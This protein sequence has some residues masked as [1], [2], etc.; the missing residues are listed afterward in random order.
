MKSSY[1][2]AHVMPWV[3][4]G[5]T[6]HATLR[7]AEAVRAGGFESVM[8]CLRE[9]DETQ[10]FFAAKGFPIIEYDAVEPS[11]TKAWRTRRENEMLA[12][13]FKQHGI[14][15]VHCADVCAAL[16]ANRAGRM[17][18]LPVI[19]HVRNPHGRESIGW[20]ER[21]FLRDIGQWVFVSQDTWRKFG[22]DVPE[23]RGV[24]IYDGIDAE[25]DDA[26]LEAAK[27]EARSSV[28]AEFGI[29]DDEKI[30]GMVARISPQKDFMTLARAA[31]RVTGNAAPQV[32]FL[33]VGD[34]ENTSAHREH[35]AKV[36]AALN[37]NNV[38]DKFLFTGFRSDVTRLIQAMDVFVLCTNFEGL[39]LVL[40]E[41]M[42]Q[43]VPTLATS[44][45][46]IPELIDEGVSGLLH[47]HGDDAMLAQ[48]LLNVLKDKMYAQKIGE[49]GRA[50]IKADFSRERFA[51]DMQNFYRTL[52]DKDNK[53]IE[54]LAA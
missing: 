22:L 16:W 30:I 19:S 45:D 1:K 36:Q 38:A 13:L 52:L 14:D 53:G 40:L 26:R 41:S 20:R 17:A 28:R 44:V 3:S 51:A 27:I 9:A 7:I 31:R 10:E 54:S 42:A 6:E 18:C 23:S 49:S 12:G 29:S 35:Y 15:V 5:G 50:H 48:Q 34:Y 33:I 25:R 8:F 43:G 39:P 2:I 24:V 4:I 11:L 47:P 21:I 37:A 46:G 32:R